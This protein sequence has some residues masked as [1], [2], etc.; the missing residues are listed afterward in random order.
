MR[1]ST[2]PTAGAKGIQ[3]VTARKAVSDERMRQLKGTYCGPAAAPRMLTTS[4]AVKDQETGKLLLLLVKRCVPKDVMMSLDKHLGPASKR[5]CWD[6]L[7]AAGPVRLDL[8]PVGSRQVS[9]WGAGVPGKRIRSNPVHSIVVGYT[10]SGNASAWTRDHPKQMEAAK[11]AVQ[12]ISKVYKQFC[13][14]QHRV[15]L[16]LAHQSGLQ[17]WNTPFASITVNRSF[18]T[19]LHFDRNCP[20]T[21]GLMVV[22]G[23]DTFKGGHLLLPQ[24]KLGVDVRV[25]DMIVFDSQMWHC[26]T[27]IRDSKQQPRMSYV[28]YAKTC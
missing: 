11:N 14:A 15:Q 12:H 7:S 13:P 20:D 16:S 26:N 24:Y 22:G 18:R 10:K 28:F 6:R 23:D 27:A 19:G 25:G 9:T 8:H 17:L 5:Q 3:V 1:P 21:Y 4:T 2:L